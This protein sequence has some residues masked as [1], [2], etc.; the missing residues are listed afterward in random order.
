MLDAIATRRID[1]VALYGGHGE[2]VILRMLVDLWF[3][4]TLIFR[5][6]HRLH[7]LRDFLC[8]LRGGMLAFSYFVAT[9]VHENGSYLSIDCF[10]M[11]EWYILVFLTS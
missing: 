5:D 8:D 3:L 6:L 10:S 7:P 9:M 4:L 11:W 2:P 1:F